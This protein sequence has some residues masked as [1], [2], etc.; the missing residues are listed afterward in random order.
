MS[1]RP[2]RALAALLAPGLIAACQESTAPVEG[3]YHPTLISVVPSAFLDAP[4]A[5]DGALVDVP[6]V[7][8][9]GGMRTY[10]ATVFDVEYQPDGTPVTADDIADG[11]AVA[12]DAGADAGEAD[13][14]GADVPTALCTADSNPGTTPRATTG[15]A[16]PSSGPIDCHDATSFSR[17]LDGHRYRVEVQGYDRDDLVPLLAGV[18]ILVDPTTGTRAK[19]PWQ[20]SCGDTCPEKGLIY[21]ARAVGDCKL[22]TDNETPS[23]PTVVVVGL[24][25]VS[26]TPACGTDSGELDHF[27]VTYSAGGTSTTATG[28]CGEEIQLDD[29]PARGTL[30]ISVL[31]YEAS[32][33]DPRWGTTCTA[34]PIQSLTVTATCAPLVD[35]GALDVDPAGALAALGSTCAAL[36]TLPAELNLDLVD[37]DGNNLAPTRYV[38][39]TTCG[40]KVRFSGV[41]R[42]PARV[43]ATLFT[44]PTQLGRAECDG[45]V[46]P[47]SDVSTD[48]TVEP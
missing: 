6:C 42:G 11:D 15:F 19:P 16:L 46:V 39:S 40:Q 17:I 32:N 41:A 7:D 33:P 14:A 21:V 28:A 24:G 8:A 3:V 30:T 36:G 18:S 4:R 27:E 22:I 10:V 43:N 2:F 12:A 47:G 25:G 44:G 34:T 13:D 45:S 48:C 35:V 26:N 20:W 9:Q 5:S 37:P 38:D 1:T 29:V 31:A 23:G